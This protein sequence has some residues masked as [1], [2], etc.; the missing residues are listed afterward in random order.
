MK[1]VVEAR[2]ISKKFNIGSR[3]RQT[4]FS[5]IR[6]TLSGE[7][8][9][10]ELWALKDISL[11]ANKGE[12]IAV[13]GPN[14]SG[15]T[16][17]FRILGGIMS[18]TTGTCDVRDEVSC[19]FELGLGFNPRF[20]ALENVYLYSALHG[21]SRKEVDK[22]LPEIVDFSGVGAFMG[23]KLSEFSSGMKARLAFATVIQ[24]V[25]GIILIDEVLSVGDIAFQKKCFAA[26]E[27]LL[28]EGNTIL[29]IS[30]SISGEIKKL[31]RKALYIDKG[32]QIAFGNAE[33]V[34]KLYIENSV[35][36]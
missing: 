23:A 29:F 5:S 4:L 13:I 3:E 35:G 6:H 26:I 19:I 17:L 28:N 9:K 30:H 21:I 31:C 12:M 32:N 2:N 20:T 22:I 36:K 33:D 10:V 1:P 16:T 18:P 24:T 14:G 15:K 27:K 34:E 8:P 7:Y 11:Y 25:K